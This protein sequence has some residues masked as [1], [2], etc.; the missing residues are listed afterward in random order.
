MKHEKNTSEIDQ[1]KQVLAK[2]F[3][4]S[5]GD[6]VPPMP[7]GLRDRIA[8]QY[9]RT[10]SS[11]VVER[12]GDSFFSL[13]GQ[14]FRRPAFAAVT[15]A[16]IMLVVATAIFNKP[17]GG[18]PFRDPGGD[19]RSAVTLVLHLIDTPTT[20]AIKS[21]GFASEALMETKNPDEL[22]AVL[23]KAGVR[24]VLDGRVGK[25]FG[26]LPGEVTPAIEEDLP[27]D[28]AALAAKVAA[29]QAKLTK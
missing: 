26:Y 19:T 15:A 9:G 5:E 23:Q 3:D 8:D 16:V 17:G 1:L 6:D 2:S 13:L 7:D 12:T 18:E 20:D 14:L 24:I 10:A 21:A 22:G 28:P 29:F 11:E 4:G 27:A 25:I